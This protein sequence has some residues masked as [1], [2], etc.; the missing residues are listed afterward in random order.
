V[1]GIY[2]FTPEIFLRVIGQY[3]QFN[4]AID[5]YPLLSYKLNPFTIFYAGSTY[6]LSDFG[7]PFGVRQ[8]ARQYFLKLQYLLRS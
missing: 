5:F 1:M 3:D 6:D 8:T 2:Q 7:S 4:K